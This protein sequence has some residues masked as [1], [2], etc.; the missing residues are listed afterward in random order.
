M[1]VSDAL[2]LRSWATFDDSGAFRYD[3]GRVWDDAL[4]VSVWIML[5]PS[6]ADATSD[7]PTMRRVTSFS[8]R[9]DFGGF[10]TVNLSAYCTKRPTD[11]RLA[12]D[13]VVEARN[14]AHIAETLATRSGPVIA[15]WG[16]S[17]SRLPARPVIDV[18][19]SASGGDL[20]CLGVTK[21]G[22]PKHPLYLRAD[23]PLERWVR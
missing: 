6:A 19:A 7:D 23:T 21:D 18:I 16:A 14:D 4:P 1:H 22:H 9:E 17:V 15:A 10:V 5:N 2:L 12:G 3:L 8:R 11:L 20:W 13:Q